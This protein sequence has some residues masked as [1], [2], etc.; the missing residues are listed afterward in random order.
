M[1]D[2]FSGINGVFIIAKLGFA[3]IKCVPHSAH[4]P[5]GSFLLWFCIGLTWS[6]LKSLNLD[7]S[8]CQQGVVQKKKSGCMEV[9]EKTAIGE[10]VH[11]NLMVLVAN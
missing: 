4:V 5:H 3:L 7:F 6:L 8:N 2:F 1:I 10:H 11:D 9:S